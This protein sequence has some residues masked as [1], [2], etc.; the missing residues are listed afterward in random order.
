MPHLTDGGGQ[1]ESQCGDREGPT[2][3]EAGRA[4]CE[5]R[6]YAVRVL[7]VQDLD[8]KIRNG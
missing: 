2:G 4:E 7:T 1:R 8:A 5:V 6:L 3:L